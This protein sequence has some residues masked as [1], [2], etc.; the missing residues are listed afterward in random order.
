MKGFCYCFA[1]RDEFIRQYRNHSKMNGSR[2]YLAEK[3]SSFLANQLAGK[4]GGNIL[5]ITFLAM[6]DF[7]ETT[8]ATAP[9]SI[10]TLHS[11]TELDDSDAI[12]ET[13]KNIGTPCE[14]K[15]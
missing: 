4:C 15:E 11:M 7:N 6:D 12:F 10:R 9:V 8:L 14:Q 5:L 3:T 2:A 13:L 1:N